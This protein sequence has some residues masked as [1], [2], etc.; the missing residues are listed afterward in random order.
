MSVTKT[1][2]KSNIKCE[3]KYTT[4]TQLELN[5]LNA[6]GKKGNYRIHAI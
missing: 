5:I 6:C 1:Y 3:E 2:S 4:Q